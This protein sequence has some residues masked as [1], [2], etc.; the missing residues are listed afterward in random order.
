MVN[1]MKL[2]VSGLWKRVWPAIKV[3][4]TWKL[5]KAVFVKVGGIWK[6]TVGVAPKNNIYNGTI[7][8][9]HGNLSPGLDIWGFHG[10]ATGGSASPT[11]TKQSQGMYVITENTVFLDAPSVQWIEMAIAGDITGLDFGNCSVNGVIG[12][13]INWEWNATAGTSY[14]RWH[15]PTPLPLTGTW[16]LIV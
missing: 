1:E 14:I 9:G 16:A 3:A 8:V 7:T 5:S 6:Q 10:Q 15:F 13:M 2:N 12:E 4:G 11:S